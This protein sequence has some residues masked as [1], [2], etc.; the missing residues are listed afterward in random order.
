MKRPLSSRLEVF[1][2]NLPRTFGFVPK[3]LALPQ[4]AHE[5]RAFMMHNPKAAGTSL[6]RALQLPQ[7]K[8]LHIWAKGAFRR[9]TWE[10]STI[11]CPVREPVHRFLSGYNYHV[12]GDYKGYLYKI[13]GEA[14][15]S[16]T[17]AEY[18]D[19]IRQYPDYLGPQALWYSYPSASKPVC[20]VILRV[21]QSFQWDVQLAGHGFGG[22]SVPKANASVNSMDEATIAKPLLR[23]I[24]AYYAQDYDV[25]GYPKPET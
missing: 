25:L 10:N 13:H 14:L 18:F 7:D 16:A 2:M 20:D 11:I 15:K 19:C 23:Q 9:A 5:R 17:H 8:T 12:A 24:V 4:R 3:Q 1:G 22:V 6:K 21:E